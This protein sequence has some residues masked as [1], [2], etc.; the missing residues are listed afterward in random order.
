MLE[1]M[2]MRL[3][4]GDDFALES[5]LASR[6]LAPFVQRC[7]NE[8]Y[9]FTLIYVWL[10]NADL[11]VER[12]LGRVAAGGHDIP[13]VTIRR[14]YERGGSNFFELYQPLADRWSVWNNSEKVSVQIASGTYAEEEVLQPD[15]WESISIQMKTA[16]RDTQ[17]D[18][19]AEAFKEA[20]ADAIETHRRMGRSIVVSRDGVVT[21]VRPSEIMPRALPHD[22]REAQADEQGS[23][24]KTTS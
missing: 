2:E 7:K 17:M 5:T 19:I 4:R 9:G 10:R 14:R 23:H 8:G 18:I 3:K 12:V 22:A 21:R 1:Q 20:V 13:E 15:I 16:T 11:A 24:P 6:S